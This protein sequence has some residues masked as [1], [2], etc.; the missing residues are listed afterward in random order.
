MDGIQR[1][2][3]IIQRHFKWSDDE[4]DAFFDR[5]QNNFTPLFKGYK[6]RRLYSAT[7][8]DDIELHQVLDIIINSM[9]MRLM[10]CGC[11]RE[12]N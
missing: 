11:L 1:R 2:L 6:K 12:K 8:Y 9:D 5:L 4:R 3:V 10:P 7:D